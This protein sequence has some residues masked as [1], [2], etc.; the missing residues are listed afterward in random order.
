[1]T[2]IRCGACGKKLGYG[3]YQTLQIKCP[4]C[5]TLNFLRAESTPPEHHEC[6]CKRQ[7]RE[8]LSKGLH[9]PS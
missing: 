5:K 7:T 6:Q 8:N 2:E 1:M 4:R 3:I 9:Y